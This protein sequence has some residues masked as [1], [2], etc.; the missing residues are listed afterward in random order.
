M[1][2][3]VFR[4]LT[5]GLVNTSISYAVFLVVFETSK[6]VAAALILAS[7]SGTT[8]SFLLNRYWVWKKGNKNSKYKFI[9][10]QVLIICINWLVLHLISYTN[11]PREIAQGFLYLVVAVFTYFLNRRVIF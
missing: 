2:R 7:I 9:L 6:S 5:A 1:K 10:L 8:C 11:F 3:P 4:Y